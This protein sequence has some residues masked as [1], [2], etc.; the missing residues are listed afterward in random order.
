M[1]Q[2]LEGIRVL[3]MTYA[4]LG[5]TSTVYLSDMGAE[6]IRVEPPEGEGVRFHR[7]V[8]NYLPQEAPSP[9]FVSMAR[10]KKAIVVDF[11]WDKGRDI[12]YQ[13]VYNHEDILSDPQTLANE[14]I[15]EMDLPAIGPTKVVGNLVHLSKTPGTVKGPPP[16]MGQHNEEILLELG[17]SWDEIM[18]INEHNREVLRQ[19]WLEGGPPQR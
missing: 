14:Y 8:G 18:E 10:G 16:E 5:P 7:G 12:I 13:R 1:P 19:K 15:V 6:V 9:Y 3:D 11:K 2:P 17:Y 4:M